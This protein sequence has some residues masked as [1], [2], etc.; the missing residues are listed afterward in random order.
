LQSFQWN[1]ETFRYRLL[2]PVRVEPGERYPLVFFLHGAG[3]RSTDNPISLKYLPDLMARSPY[4]EKF[5][6]FVLVPQCRPAQNGLGS[7]RNRQRR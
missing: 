1:E 6:A 2:V 5:Q 3:E 4:R 7:W